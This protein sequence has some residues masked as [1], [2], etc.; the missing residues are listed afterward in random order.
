MIIFYETGKYYNFTK[1]VYTFQGQPGSPGPKGDA[2]DPGPLGPN[3][4]DGER[5]PPGE[6][7]PDV[8]EII[9]MNM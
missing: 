9:M 1:L 7:G 8:S 5:G 6:M 4:A 2:G 3:G